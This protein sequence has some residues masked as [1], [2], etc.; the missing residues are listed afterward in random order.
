[1]ITSNPLIVSVFPSVPLPAVPQVAGPG[2]H[3]VLGARA[4]HLLHPGL[5]EDDAVGSA[6]PALPPG[7][8]ALGLVPGHGH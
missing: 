1:M 7:R 2:D 5:L 8:R 4:A 3:R 6:L